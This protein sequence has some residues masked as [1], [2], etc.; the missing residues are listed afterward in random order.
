MKPGGPVIAS[1]DVHAIFPAQ[2]GAVKS[3]NVFGASAGL[4]RFVL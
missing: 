1:S 3:S 4:I 2:R